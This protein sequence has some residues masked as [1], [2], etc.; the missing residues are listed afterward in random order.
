[1]HGYVIVF[2]GLLPFEL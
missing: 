1:M 2:A